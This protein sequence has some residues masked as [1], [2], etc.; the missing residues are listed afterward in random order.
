[1]SEQKKFVPFVSPES[2]MAE[3]TIRALIIGLIMCV[4]LG[5]ANAYLGLK[6]GMTIA[7][8]YPAAVIGMALLKIMKGSILEENFART[9]GSIG[10]SI[11]A[12][13][14]FTLP[15]FFIAGI[16]PEFATTG[17]YLES[18]AIM[19]AGGVLGIMFVALLRR[20]MVE[21]VEL[22]FPESVAAGEIHKAGRAGGTGAK[23]LF[24]AMGIGALIQTLGQLKLFATS[25]EK[26]V[27]FSKATINLKATGTV[28]VQ[29]GMILSSPGVSPAYIGVGYIIGPKLASLNFSGGLLAWGLFVPIITYFLG[30]SLFPEAS[31]ATEESWVGMANN[32][33]RFIVRPIAI[34]GMLTG[35]GY[36]LFRMRKSLITG[37]KR[38]IGDVKKAATGEHVAIRTDQDINFKW[39]MIGILAASVG[40]FFIYNH[41]AQDVVAALVATIVMVVAGFFFAAV[42]GYL[43][44]IIGSSNNPISGL[45][46]S[47][48]LIAALLMVALGMTGATGIAAVLGVAAVVC[49]AAAVAGEMLQD[50]KVGHILGGT[51]WKMQVG[52]IIGVVLASVV[53]FI[54]L[55]ILHQG[56]INTGGTGFGGKA[57]PAPQASLMALLSQGIVGGEMAWPL[58]IV[59]MIMGFGFVLM[60]VKSPMLV[61]VG[62]YLPLETTFA[63]FIGGLIKGVVERF[64]ESRKHNAAQRARVENTG[65]LIAAGL[66]AGEALI[67]LVFAGFAFFEFR[68]FSIFETP[69]FFVSLLVFAFI[70][71]LLIRIP[72]KNAG[73]ADEPAPPSAV[74]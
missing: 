55:V 20:V 46:L 56:D 2:S 9:V 18:S 51:P 49:V 58:I 63:I 10:E 62:M 23:F 44:G 17:H 43:V 28:D 72:V 64:N 16:W 54:P 38:S 6:A 57:L 34:G 13:A 25:W 31:G 60:Q 66:I 3:F 33:W 8:T 68:L 71:W 11:A 21:D 67:G 48:L 19:I 27:S 39:V 65:V 7:A 42:S 50:L 4:I 74:M 35:A 70:A 22:P 40:T 15:A 14:I 45:T 32:V 26:F 53:M 69:S 52:D 1:M 41:F 5:A 73:R 12:G 59:G 61:A 24:G 30:P 36:T 47:T 29:S 37:I